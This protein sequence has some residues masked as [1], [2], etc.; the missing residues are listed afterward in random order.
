MNG[1]KKSLYSIWVGNNPEM[2]LY[3]LHDVVMC[4]LHAGALI[5]ELCGVYQ[6][7]YHDSQCVH[8]VGGSAV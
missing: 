3:V 2:Y 6:N 5:N 7:R 8:S 1:I 4:V